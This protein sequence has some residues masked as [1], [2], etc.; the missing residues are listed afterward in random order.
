VRK[1]IYREE[2][3]TNNDDDDDRELSAC[4][5]NAHSYE[6]TLRFEAEPFDVIE[7]RPVFIVVIG[8]SQ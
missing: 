4:R 5:R 1:A 7:L 2:Y 8:F 6:Y 3:W